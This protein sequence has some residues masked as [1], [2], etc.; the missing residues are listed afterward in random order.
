MVPTVKSATRISASSA[1]FTARCVDRHSVVSAKT[2]STVKCVTSECENQV[3][4]LKCDESYEM[5]SSED[6]DLPLG[7]ISSQ[8]WPID[9][10]SQV[11][12][13]TNPDRAQQFRSAST[14]RTGTQM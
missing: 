3:C 4:D 12:A 13:S 1:K 5:R 6:C 7:K 11:A 14:Y 8:R 2:A 10:G 9:L